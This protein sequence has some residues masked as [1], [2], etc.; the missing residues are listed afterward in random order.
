MHSV[1]WARLK[2]HPYQ[3]HGPLEATSIIAGHHDGGAANMKR[4]SGYFMVAAVC[5]FFPVATFVRTP[6]ENEVTVYMLSC[7]GESINDVCHGMEKTYL[8][9]TYEVSVDQHSVSYSTMGDPGMRH[10]LSFCAVH[11]TNCWL[12]QWSSDEVPK[13]RFGMVSEKY[14][15][16]ATCVTDTTHRPPIQVPRWRWWLVRLHEKLS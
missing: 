14:V 8:P 16:I 2:P 15:E 10:E 11:D 4:L 9:F 3:A 5:C 7:D 13:T 1:L 6:L 12:C